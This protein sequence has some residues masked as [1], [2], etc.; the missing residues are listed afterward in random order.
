MQTAREGLRRRRSAVALALTI[1][2]VP[3]SALGQTPRAVD[4]AGSTAPADGADPVAEARAEFVR[5]AAFIRELQY[6]EALAAFERSASLRPHAVTT[7]NIG[8]CQR[9]LGRYALAQK[10]LKRALEQDAAAASAELSPSL[11]SELNGFLEQI[12]RLLARVEVVM[13]PADAALTVDGHPLE[14]VHG[15]AGST[16]V[17]VAGTRPPGPGEPPPAST[18]TMVTDPGSHVITLSRKGFADAVVNKAFGP[19][20]TTSLRLELDRLPATIA[21]ASDRPGA[22]V[23]VDALDVG[24]A[25]IDIQRPAGKHHV[26]VK[27]LGFVTYEADLEAHP[28]ERIDLKATL[29]EDKPA[30]TQRWWFWTAAGVLVAG[31][32]TATYFATRPAP[33]RPPLDGGGLG[34]TLEAR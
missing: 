29:R 33:E 7:Y 28:G 23:T 9:A 24:V 6:A 18:F 10:T 1:T 2:M 26:A 20:T 31:V 4:G 14:V 22:V 27:K 16:P 34:W 25:P 17:L 13:T 21:V 5:G 8:A 32:A 15:A 3:T 12:E 11:K 30:L 19:G